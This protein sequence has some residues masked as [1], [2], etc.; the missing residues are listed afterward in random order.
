M[1]VWKELGNSGAL[2][3]GEAL[4]I[5]ATKIALMIIVQSYHLNL[6]LLT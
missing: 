5:I 6:E 1:R 2:F 4:M 3:T